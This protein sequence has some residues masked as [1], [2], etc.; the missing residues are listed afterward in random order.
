MSDIADRLME[1]IPYTTTLEQQQLYAEAAARIRELEEKLHW[2]NESLVN[3][4][5]ERG[6]EKA[7]REELEARV[8][9][10]ESHLSLADE[11]ASIV[12]LAEMTEENKRD[13][14]GD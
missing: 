13:P 2:C 3:T 7:Y 14:R 11:A 12:K 5:E 4:E 6:M 10:L 8:A 9:E 1:A